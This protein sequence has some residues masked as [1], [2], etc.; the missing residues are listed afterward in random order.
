MILAL[1][2]QLPESGV[3]LLTNATLPAP[4]AIA[5]VAVTS[6]VGSGVLHGAMAQDP[7]PSCTKK[8]FPGAIEPDRTVTC[9]VVPVSEVYCTDHPVTLTVVVPRLY[10]SMKS[11]L[12]KAAGGPEFPPPP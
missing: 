3:L 7:A 5:M 12:Y 4:A 9:Q 1:D 10:S 11:F 6:G 2:G 8:Y